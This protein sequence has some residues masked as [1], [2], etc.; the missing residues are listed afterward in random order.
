MATS[1]SRV[2][3]SGRENCRTSLRE[4]ADFKRRSLRQPALMLLSARRRQRNAYETAAKPETVID[5]GRARLAV[6]SD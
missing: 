2:V 1:R 3:N 6:R 4:L 5:K